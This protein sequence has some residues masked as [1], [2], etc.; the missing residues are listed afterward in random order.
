MF[1][2]KSNNRGL[3]NGVIKQGKG[4][5]AKYDG[6]HLGVFDTVEDAYSVYAK[7]K[8][9]GITEAVCEYE[10]IIP[11][12]VYQAILNHEFK[13]ENDANYKAS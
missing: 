5:L 1:M 8:K 6:E 11:F 9:E 7:K 10:N 4:Y 13:I 2:N 12:K 3:P